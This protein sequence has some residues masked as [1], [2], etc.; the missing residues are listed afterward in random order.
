VTLVYEAGRLRADVTAEIP[1]TVYPA[2]AGPDRARV[3]G[4]DLGIIHPYAVAGPDGQALLVSGRAVRAEHHL[5]GVPG[6]T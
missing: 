6:A 2:G 4:V 1:V 3:A 5:P